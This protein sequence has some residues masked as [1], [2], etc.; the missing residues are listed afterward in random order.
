[1][2][3]KEYVSSPPFSLLY[4]YHDMMN[5]RK[6]LFMN[7]FDDFTKHQIHCSFL[8]R[9]ASFILP[10]CQSNDLFRMANTLILAYI[11]LVHFGPVWRLGAFMLQGR[12]LF[13]LFLSS[14]LTTMTTYRHL[15]LSI[16]LS[17]AHVYQVWSRLF[18]FILLTWFQNAIVSHMLRFV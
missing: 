6:R 16:S 10:M 4:C 7:L 2:L 8:K 18:N 5:S 13:P 9:Q 17:I 3:Y 15:H 12:S 1:M 14:Q 11:P